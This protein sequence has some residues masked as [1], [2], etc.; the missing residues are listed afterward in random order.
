MVKITCRAQLA[1]V[2]F[3]R[4]RAQ[5]LREIRFA[6]ERPNWV[7]G[8]FNHT[9][10]ASAFA[11]AFRTAS[12]LPP[13]SPLSP[14]LSP[15]HLLTS[16]SPHPSQPPHRSPPHRLQALP[17]HLRVLSLSTG[18]RHSRPQVASALARATIFEACIRVC[19]PASCER[20]HSSTLS[21]CYLAPSRLLLR[22]VGPTP[23]VHPRLAQR[24]RP[25]ASIRCRQGPTLTPPVAAKN[26]I[27]L[28]SARLWSVA[29]FSARFPASLTSSSVSP[30]TPLL[31]LRSALRF[32]ALLIHTSCTTAFAS[33]RP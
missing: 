2:L 1:L 30:G 16:S 28:T 21:A 4:A 27:R 7:C 19:A 5:A 20:L 11:L 14:P 15:P 12:P 10:L 18:A 3:R 8:P 33:V 25:P 13:I 9:T 24:R 32:P 6:I 29:F 23:L 17:Q 22:C 31:L 26:I